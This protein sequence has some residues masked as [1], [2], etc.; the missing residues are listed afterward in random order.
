MTAVSIANLHS[1]IFAGHSRTSE[2]G[3]ATLLAEA[4]ITMCHGCSTGV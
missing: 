1:A 4:Q 2:G 3:V